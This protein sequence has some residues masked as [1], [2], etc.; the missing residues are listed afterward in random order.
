MRRDPSPD[1]VR[2]FAPGREPSS[3][4]ALNGLPAR[5]AAYF[6]AEADRIQRLADTAVS[7]DEQVRYA[8]AAQVYRDLAWLETRD[9]HTPSP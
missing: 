9:G 3:P 1:A 2:A 4:Q 7:P 5:R 8:R 6:Q